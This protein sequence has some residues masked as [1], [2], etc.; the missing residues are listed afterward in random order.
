MGE[1]TSNREINKI[2]D[3]QARRAVLEQI[4]NINADNNSLTD[5]IIASFCE[6][7]IDQS[8]CCVNMNSYADA[9]Y[10]LK[11]I[12]NFENKCFLLINTALKRESVGEHWLVYD[13]IKKDF[14]DGK[15]R[16]PSHYKKGGVWAIPAVTYNSIRYQ[17][18]NSTSCGHLC[19]AYMYSRTNNISIEKIVGQ[20]TP[21]TESEREEFDK[22]CMA[23]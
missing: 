6:K 23:W 4:V 19:C 2:Q 16:K 7:Y 22:G 15:G 1:Y 18:N 14:F 9:D 10:I 17:S 12:Q 3:P 13:T 21:T 11:T 5:T 8:L 20:K